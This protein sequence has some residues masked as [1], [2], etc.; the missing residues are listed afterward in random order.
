MRFV[1]LFAGLGGF[2]LALTELGHECVFACEKDADLRE[3]YTSNFGLEPLQNIKDVKLDEV[4]PHEILCAGFP[5]QPFS[6]AGEQLGFSCPVNGDLFAY[7]LNIIRAREP[8]LVLL[9]NVPNFARHN[10]GDTITEVCEQLEKLKYEVDYHSFSPHQFGVPQIRER[11]FI[12][13]S[14]KGLG[15][16]VWPK[17]ISQQNL[18]IRSVLDLAPPEARRI[19]PQVIDCLRV[20]QKFLDEFPLEEQLPSFPIWSMEFDATYPFEETTPFALG[21][22]N[23]Q[24][25]RGSHGT[26]L[27][28]MTIDEIMA[29]LPAYARTRA[30]RFPDWKIAFIRQNRQLYARHKQWIDNW[31]PEIVPFPPSYQKLEWNCKGEP[32][33]LTNYIVQMRASGVRV[34]R[35]TT[36]PSLVAMTTTQVPIVAWEERYM[37]PRECARLQSMGH[38]AHLPETSVRAYKALGNAVNVEVVKRIASN[39]IASFEI[40]PT[41][42]Q[43]RAPKAK[44]LSML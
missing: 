4:P 26:P 24:S 11:I 7:V 20:W 35:A 2:H 12:V 13:A 8:G 33:Q 31:I 32:R 43:L 15:N 40:R 36:A 1:D 22:K 30:R 16:F 23:L 21:E 38:L 9:E 39:L 27:K 34:K 37:T 44:Q 41:R 29:A 17:A 18:T 10:N 3:L 5:C 28:G 42:L 6:K 25:F 14:R 19:S